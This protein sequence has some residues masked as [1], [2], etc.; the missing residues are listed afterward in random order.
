MS[1]ALK[2]D[3]REFRHAL[4]TY[5]AATKKGIPEILNHAA[6]QAAFRAMRLSPTADSTWPLRAADDPS[7][8]RNKNREWTYPDRLYYALAVKNGAEVGD[9]A[10]KAA[11]LYKKRRSSRG[12]I[13]AQWGTIAAKMGAKTTARPISGKLDIEVTRATILSHVAEL[14]NAKLEG[15]G[16]GKAVSKLASAWNRALHDAIWGKGGMV[17]YANRKLKA[18]WGKR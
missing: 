3:L 1:V 9:R 5:Q 12:Y 13:K 15:S 11:K 6:A 16:Q 7:K 17:E 2:I 18:N 4:K 8:K 14:W 10:L